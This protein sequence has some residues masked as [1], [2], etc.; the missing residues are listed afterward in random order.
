LDDPSV[1]AACL[2]VLSIGALGTTWWSFSDL[3]GAV[4]TTRISTATSKTLAVLAPASY[5]NHQ[6]YRRGRDITSRWVLAV[7]WHF[8]ARYIQRTSGSLKNGLFVGGLFVLLVSIV[9]LNVP[10]RLLVQRTSERSIGWDKGEN[11]DCYIIGG[12]SSDPLLFCPTRSE[13][14][15]ISRKTRGSSGSAQMPNEHL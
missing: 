14:I 9:S 10:Y 3:L 5:P 2:L 7:A 6:L 12:S 8:M 13:R 4:F 1:L 11:Y 15:P